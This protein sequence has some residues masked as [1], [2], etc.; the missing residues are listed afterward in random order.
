MSARAEPTGKPLRPAVLRRPRA[1]TQVLVLLCL[2][3]AISY[4]DRANISTAAP[5]IQAQLGLT[6]TQLGIALGAFSV[7]Y[8]LLSIFGGAI[9]AKLGPRVALALIGVL[10]G[11]AT[12]ATGFSIGLASLIGARLLLGLS[13][14]GAFPVATQVMSRWMPTR[15][16]GFAQGVVHSSSRLGNALAPL[17]VAG[18]IAWAGW[19]ESFFV[20]GVL[21]VL[22]AVLWFAVF[23]NRPAEYRGITEQELAELPEEAQ[24]QAAKPRVPWRRLLVSLAPVVFVDFGYGWTLWVFLTWLPSFLSQSFGLALSSFALFTSLV[25]AAGVVGDTL[26][27]VLS[28]RLTRRLSIGAARRT[29]IVVGL[30]GAG[31]ALTPL[32]LTHQL[33]VATACLAVAFFFLELTNAPLWSIPMDVAPVWAGTA[34]GVM[35]TGFGIAGIASPI[36]FGALVQVAGWQVPFGVSIALL[37]VAAVV[38]AVMRPKPVHADESPVL[39]A[40]EQG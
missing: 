5:S 6:D 35:N 16:Y 3:Y 1:R 4:I 38:A 25:L 20:I 23:R 28:D 10:W 24:Q 2:M 18:L 17:L 8:A 9:G 11:V 22:W 29:M 13:E 36:V 31:V 19:R 12:I 37:G 26:G 40:A 27:G 34:S 30:V 14:S 21:S 7:P 15:R 39:R 33:V 32:V